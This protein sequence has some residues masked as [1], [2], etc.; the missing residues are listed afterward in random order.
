VLSGVYS[1]VCKTNGKGY[2]GSSVE[3]PGRWS[4]HLRSLR[5]GNHVNPH[6][7]NAF[8]IYGEDSFNFTLLENLSG[9]TEREIREIE[10]VYLDLMDWGNSFNVCKTAKGGEV[11]KEANERRRES[12]R[13]FHKNNPDAIRGENNPFYGRTH[14]QSSK[15]A[16]SIAN[17]GKVRSDEFKK[18]K[19]EFM[20]NRRGSHHKEEYLNSIREKYSGGGNPMAIQV[21]LN[22]ITYLTKKEAL[23]ALDL[24]YSYQL[25]K[26]LNA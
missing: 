17:T 16:I 26:L 10:Q 25:D 13:E 18:Q 14:D 19:S 9:C 8:S 12:L 1:I 4:K 6:L 2:I 7:Q 22:G 21:T 24:K 5:K 23:K 11:T 15:D 3:V 20:S